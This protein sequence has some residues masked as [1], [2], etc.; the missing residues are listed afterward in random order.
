MSR[1]AP[2]P[3]RYTVRLVERPLISHALGAP[4]FLEPIVR[5]P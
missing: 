2:L 4:V 3:Q 5:S 1:I